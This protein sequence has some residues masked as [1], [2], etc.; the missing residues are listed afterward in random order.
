M[1]WCSGCGIAE[2]V[3]DE[4][5]PHLKDWAR[6]DVAKALVEIFEDHDCDTMEEASFYDIAYPEGREDE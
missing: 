3:W 2:E 4:I 1:G 6:Q 5:S